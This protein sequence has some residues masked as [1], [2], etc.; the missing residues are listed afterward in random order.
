[1]RSA[2]GSPPEFPREV[3]VAAR[4][5]GSSGG[6][7]QPQYFALTTPT[8][9]YVAVASGLDAALSAV[10]GTPMAAIDATA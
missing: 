6:E 4:N 5:S 10:D 7:A 3:I 2:A 1:M 9:A 8:P